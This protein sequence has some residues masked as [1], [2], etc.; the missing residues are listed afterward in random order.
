[1][2]VTTEDYLA[3]NHH[4]S[5]YCWAFDEG[6][7][8]AYA[9]LWAE[10]GVFT[11]VTPDPV[12]GHE[13]LKALVRAG[14][15]RNKRRGRH[16]VGNLI[17]EYGASRDAVTARYYN[18]VTNWTDGGAFRAMAMCTVQLKRD[19]DGWLI[20]RNDSELFWA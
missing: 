8:E 10:D 19:G 18:F 15:E 12:V 17:C 14:A 5:R 2:R 16:L 3:I 7:D 1:M 4:L 6:N 20:A 13:G 11:G 9:A